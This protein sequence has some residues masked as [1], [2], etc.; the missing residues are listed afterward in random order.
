ME[1]WVRSFNALWIAQL[2]AIIG[3]STSNPIIPLYL[4]ELG[5][6]DPAA[7]NWWTG[8]INGISSLA[9]AI[10]APMWGALADNYGRKIMLLRAMI[11]GSI[12][13]GL[14]AVTNSPWQ[15]LLLKTL[16]GCITGTIAAA[17][18]LTASIVPAAQVGY[19]LGL[20]QMAV[21]IGNSLG[22]MLG[23][24]ITDLAGARVNFLATAVLLAAS[25][26]IVLK[27]VKEEFVPA[28]KTKSIFRNAIP[29]FSVLASSRELF[30]LM[31]VIFFI[32]F[33][34]SVAG[35][36][37][38]L[39][40]LDMT[41]VLEGVGSLSGLIIGVAS[42]GGALGS[43]LA[44]KISGKLGYERVLLVC[45]AG[46]FLFYLPQGFATEPWQLV[47]LRFVS[48]FFMGGTMP[49]ANALI[50]FRAERKKQGA[51]YGLSSAMSSGGNAIGPAF[52]ALAAT[53]IGY[54][55]VFFTTTI[56]LGA[57]GIGLGKQ[58]FG[59]RAQRSDAESA[60]K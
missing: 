59:L 27:N 21:F 37:I 39:V 56:L 18:V 43:V 24:M 38:P 10:F 5:I 50:A 14:L 30:P 53:M 11:G 15:V 58:V 40:V 4:T 55:A 36:I 34:N 8:A 44:G 22:P 26:F 60:G 17:T 54:P 16:Q 41:N 12:I 7:L 47:L 35:P 3:F 28:P 42:I 29:D 32:Q 48:G 51:I 31:V 52:G 33:S 20:I 13:I 23:G 45:I 49:T 2:F 9:L 57:L 6:R 1:A 46:A 25:A 19:R